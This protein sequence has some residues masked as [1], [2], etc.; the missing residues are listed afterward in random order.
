M[1]HRAI[2]SKMLGGQPFCCK[3]KNLTNS[4][5]QVSFNLIAITTC[6]NE[7]VG[8]LD[9]I[10]LEPNESINQCSDFSSV[11]NNNIVTENDCAGEDGGYTDS[12]GKLI[13]GKTRIRSVKIGSLEVT[14]LVKDPRKP[15]GP[16]MKANYEGQPLKSKKEMAD[17]E[18]LNKAMMKQLE[19]EFD[20][21][22]NANK[23]EPEEKPESFAKQ[24]K[25][26]NNSDNNVKDTQ[27]KSEEYKRFIIVKLG[28]YTYRGQGNNMNGG[29]FPYKNSITN[30][31]WKSNEFHFT[32][33][34]EGWPSYFGNM[35]GPRNLI[36]KPE[37]N[38]QINGNFL[39]GDIESDNKVFLQELK[40][41]FDFIFKNS[42]Q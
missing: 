23:P 32:I 14:E 20:N 4:Q 33:T 30:C 42:K 10:T 35:N 37:T 26:S 39:G 18:K 31:Y 41:A 25:N 34:G 9:I 8:G 16:A 6:G 36:I 2:D 12:K 38:L 1:V 29:K 5:L 13:K 17:E 27:K 40:T 28:N 19:K 7:V 21:E 22:N 15:S 24:P 11:L 3:I